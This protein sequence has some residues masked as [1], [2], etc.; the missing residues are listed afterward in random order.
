MAVVLVVNQKVW[1]EI[2][3]AYL[4]CLG[5]YLVA[6][7]CGHKRLESRVLFPGRLNLPHHGYQTHP[8]AISPLQTILGHYPHGRA[9]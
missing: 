4:N 8:S 6:L 9:M 7:Q 5:F 2:S 1:W 3:L